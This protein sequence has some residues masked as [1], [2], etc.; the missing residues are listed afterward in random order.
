MIPFGKSKYI[1]GLPPVS[2]A[3]KLLEILEKKPIETKRKPL[4]I[5][6]LFLLQKNI[7]NN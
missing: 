2:K 4:L 5:E 1:N 6:G 3:F 7:K